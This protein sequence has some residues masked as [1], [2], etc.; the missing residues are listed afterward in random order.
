MDPVPSD[1]ESHTRG[2][3]GARDALA[4]IYTDI[5]E[6]G[7][8]LSRLCYQ[9]DDPGC[10][11]APDDKVIVPARMAEPKPEPAPEPETSADEV[12]AAL[13][14]LA[15]QGAGADDNC[16]IGV[17]TCL[18]SLGH[19]FEE[20]DRWAA[21]AGCS[22]TNRRARWD[23]FKGSDTD[24]SAIIGMAVNRGWKGIGRPPQGDGQ[25][26]G[27][28]I[29]TTP[30]SLEEIVEDYRS[31]RN[32]M[33]SHDATAAAYRYCR[34]YADDSLVVLPQSARVAASM[35]R[36]RFV[37]VLLMNRDTGL[38]SEADSEIDMRLTAIMDQAI[39]HAYLLVKKKEISLKKFGTIVK[40][41]NETRTPNAA[42]A[43][44]RALPGIALTMS[45]GC[46][47]RVCRLDELD[48]LPGYLP[49][50]NG[51]VDLRKG[52]LV[53]VE[54]VPDLLFQTRPGTPNFVP[55]ARHPIVD[56]LLSHLGPE[57]EEFIWS[58]SGRGM[59]GAPNTENGLLALCGTTPD[60]GE[61]KTTFLNALY[62]GVGPGHMGRIS[63]DA[64]SKRGRGKHGP[65]PERQVL[66]EML[67]AFFR[68][69]Q[70][71]G[72]LRGDHQGFH[73]RGD[74][75]LSAQVQPGGHDACPRLHHHI[76]QQPSAVGRG[77]RNATAAARSDLHPASPSRPGL[78]PRRRSQEPG[79]CSGRGHPGQALPCR[80]RT[81][82]GTRPSAYT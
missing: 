79:P 63:S 17:G 46:R 28:S 24:Y 30:G 50:E 72:H 71:L 6:S 21:A 5:D 73:Q 70:R 81:P 39:D 26:P 52:C 13:D 22:C 18:K 12:R 8:N 3:A 51:L 48:A 68:G 54:E 80:S 77:P 11:I 41:A 75:L 29:S 42:D 33:T 35:G 20:F 62:V 76:R 78:R 43:M 60:G 31:G 25:R 65:T 19:D 1:D 40:K 66:I 4:G 10:Y 27:V 49:A 14:Y 59:H 82:A 69:N 7:K 64:V 15:A 16:L 2:W 55:D 58:W 9:S 47:P 61:G 23:S 34:Q 57:K 56:H 32:L 37:R 53:P 74:D 45:K 36:R 38:W 44:V 67:F